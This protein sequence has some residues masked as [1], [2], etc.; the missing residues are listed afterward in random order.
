MDS[1]TRQGQPEEGVQETGFEEAVK[2]DPVGLQGPNPAVTAPNTTEKE[3]GFSR[4]AFTLMLLGGFFAVWLYGF[5]TKAYDL[6]LLGT[7]I[8]KS[9]VQ[10]VFT[11]PAQVG[12]V[13]VTVLLVALWVRRRR[14]GSSLPAKERASPSTEF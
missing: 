12:V 1:L 14:K 9:N 10:G 5:V 2:T 7:L 6:L 11:S 3:E 8:Q 4:F 13:S